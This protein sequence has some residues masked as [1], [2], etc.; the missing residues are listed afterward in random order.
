MAD[1]IQKNSIITIIIKNLTILTMK[2]DFS[3]IIIA[4]TTTVIIFR[5]HK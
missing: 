2:I 3:K 1:F 5:D 4:T